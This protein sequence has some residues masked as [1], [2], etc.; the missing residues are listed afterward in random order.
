MPYLFVFFTMVCVIGVVIRLAS[1]LSNL[2]AH[3]L[4]MSLK[5]LRALVVFCGGMFLLAF[6][7]HDKSHMPSSSIWEMVWIIIGCFVTAGILQIGIERLEC[8]AERKEL[9]KQARLMRQ[10]ELKV[11][12]EIR[13]TARMVSRNKCDDND[14]VEIIDVTAID[15]E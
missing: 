13:E 9:V 1:I 4:L 5:I 10:A 8:H 14:D 3:P 6:V 11:D 7:V 12:Q 15:E 2:V